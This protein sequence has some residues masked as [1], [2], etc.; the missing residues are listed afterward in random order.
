MLS[1]ATWLLLSPVPVRYSKRQSYQEQFHYSGKE[2]EQNPQRP[3]YRTIAM[4]AL[5]RSELQGLERIDALR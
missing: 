5:S 4:G 2:I 3:G 1:P